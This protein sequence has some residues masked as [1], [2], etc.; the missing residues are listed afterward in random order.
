MMLSLTANHHGHS[1]VPVNA[2]SDTEH[3]A[4][5]HWARR[6]R[7]TRLT[8]GDTCHHGGTATEDA[9]VCQTQDAARETL[10]TLLITYVTIPYGTVPY[11]TIR[12][13]MSLY[14]IPSH[15]GSKSLRER[16]REKGR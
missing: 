10:G 16:E 14:N 8:C 13:P 11:V 15:V 2:A 9:C 5:K 1:E 12:Y 4:A 6:A 7:Q 3:R